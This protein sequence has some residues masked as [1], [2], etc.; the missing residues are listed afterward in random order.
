MNRTRTAPTCPCKV[1]YYDNG[2][3]NESCEKCAYKC[4]SC[5]TSAS[6][7]DTCIENNRNL[8]L[9]CAC[10]DGYFDFGSPLC[11]KCDS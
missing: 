5:T 8:A 3:N 4:Y 10:H 11:G 9:S 7:C 2:T 6:T 1:G